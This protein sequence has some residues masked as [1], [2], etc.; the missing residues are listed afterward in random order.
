MVT[1]VNNNTPLDTVITQTLAAERHAR[2]NANAPTN[3]DTNANANQSIVA[4][5][6]IVHFRIPGLRSGRE[7]TVILRMR[8]HVPIPP[9]DAD[10]IEPLEFEITYPRAWWARMIQKIKDNER[11]TLLPCDTD[12]ISVVLLDPPT[13]ARLFAD[14][15][16]CPG[17]TSNNDATIH[18]DYDGTPYIRAE[19]STR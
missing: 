6:S 9:D 16:Q 8:V 18:I 2:T 3:A 4:L 5:Q 15:P 14:I 17:W 13:G 1:Q 7:V 19:I 10:T 11:I 12:T